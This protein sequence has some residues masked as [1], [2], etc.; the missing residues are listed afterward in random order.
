MYSWKVTLVQEVQGMQ[1]SSFQQHGSLNYNTIIITTNY[2]YQPSSIATTHYH[3]TNSNI[4]APR[5]GFYPNI[6]PQ[7][8]HNPYFSSGEAGLNKCT[9]FWMGLSST[10]RS[11]SRNRTLRTKPS[12]DGMASIT[13]A[14]FQQDLWDCSSTT[15]TMSSTFKFSLTVFHLHRDMCW[16]TISF[17]HLDQNKSTIYCTRL[18]CFEAYRSARSVLSGAS[19]LGMTFDFKVNMWLGVKGSR[20]WGSLISSTL[21]GQLFITDDTSDNTVINPSSVRHEPCSCK[22]PSITRRATPIRRSHTPPR[23]LA[24]GGL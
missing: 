20:D 8:E 21:S 19:V 22:T 16:W 5:R 1:N 17:F 15:R 11:A 6:H 3:N 24:A 10:D 18:H 4:K 7:A 9:T 2:T 12:C 14:S 13:L 23:W